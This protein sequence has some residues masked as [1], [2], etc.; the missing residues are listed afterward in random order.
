MK[1]T[2]NQDGRL[3][4]GQQEEVFIE[5]LWRQPQ[6]DTQSQVFLTSKDTQS[7]QQNSYTAGQ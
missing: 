1:A 7:D 5:V 2:H 3:G 6:S 4:T